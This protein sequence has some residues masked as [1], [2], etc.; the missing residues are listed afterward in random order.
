MLGFSWL[1]IATI[2]IL[3]PI[4]I[5]LYARGYREARRV[6]P[7]DLK[8]LEDIERM[9]RLSESDPRA[10]EAMAQQLTQRDDTELMVLRSRASNDKSARRE[11]IA[12]L[13]LQSQALRLA[14]S[15]RSV[16]SPS[17]DV[18]DD[19]V[20]LERIE[21]ELGRLRQSSS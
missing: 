2:V 15:A 21:A 16:S 6:T 4:A 14:N 3:A 17:H 9:V 13:A 19:E 1:E 11:L 20:A 5:F 18:S 12:R 10:A 8:R 7:A